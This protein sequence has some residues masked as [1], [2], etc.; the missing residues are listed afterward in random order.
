MLKPGGYLQWDELD[1]VNLCVKK[2]DPAVKTPALDQLREISYS[3]GQYDWVLTIPGMMA[4]TGFQGASIDFIRDPD[5]LIRAFNEQ[6][7][8]T[9]EFLVWSV[10]R[11]GEKETASKSN[12]LGT[13]IKSLWAGLR[14]AFR[15][16]FAVPVSRLFLS[17]K[18]FCVL[19]AI[20]WWLLSCG[21]IHGACAIAVSVIVRSTFGTFLPFA[22]PPLVNILGNG[23]GNSVLVF[24]SIVLLP[25]V[26]IL[27]RYGGRIRK[28][29]ALSLEFIRNYVS[30]FWATRIMSFSQ[31]DRF[32]PQF[33]SG[34]ALTAPSLLSHLFHSHSTPPFITPS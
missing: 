30:R 2:V 33:I 16:L 17:D 14:C 3:N 15:G 7:L 29:R 26:P 32:L 24:I 34:K 11:S 1:C 28:K 13:G 27:M 5:E 25:S 20:R 22:G 12:C 10:A 21:R 6:H 8:L 18:L 23:W 9:M 19:D 4:E 31:P